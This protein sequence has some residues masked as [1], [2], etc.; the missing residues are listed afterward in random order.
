M[1]TVNKS[2][3]KKLIGTQVVGNIVVFHRVSTGEE[4]GR[5]DTGMMGGEILAQ[6]LAYG[7]KQIVSDI[8]ASADGIE[9]KC[10]GMRTAIA[11]LGAG[12]WPRRA[13]APASMDKAIETMMRALG[14]TREQVCA[15]LGIAE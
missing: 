3:R 10:A 6:T 2:D 12:T 9:E 8:V 15:R 14:E 5:V 13:G 4:I 11:S 1:A 7:V